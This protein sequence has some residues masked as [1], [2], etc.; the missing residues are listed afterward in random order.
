MGWFTAGKKY[1]IFLTLCWKILM[2]KFRKSAYW[3]YFAVN[4]IQLWIKY[5]FGKFWKL[6]KTE[7]NVKR[8][9]SPINWEKFIVCKRVPAHFLRHP[10]LTQLAPF[11]KFLLSLPSFLSPPLRYFRQFPHPHA[12]KPSP[13]LIWHTNLLYSYTQ[14]TFRQ[15]RM[16]SFS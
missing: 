9:N 5:L 6:S 1:I 2:I 13:A 3:K 4:L 10:P 14:V 7:K 8:K 12:D 11:L 16:A 15:L